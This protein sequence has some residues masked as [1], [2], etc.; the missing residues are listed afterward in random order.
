[1]KFLLA[2]TMLVTLVSSMAFGKL[3]RKIN[4]LSLKK[5]RL[6][7]YSTKNYPIRFSMC[8]PPERNQREEIFDVDWDTFYKFWGGLTK[9]VWLA[10]FF[11]L[12][13]WVPSLF[14]YLLHLFLLAS[15]GGE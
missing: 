2:F 1:M 10:C 3:V 15:V 13:C 6:K 4:L 7:I 12:F 8:L 9:L 5:P 11:L 14:P